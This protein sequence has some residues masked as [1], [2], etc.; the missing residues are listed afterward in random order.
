MA[1]TAKVRFAD[2]PGGGMLTLWT[3]GVDDARVTYGD[4]VGPSAP[5]GA[6]EV[7]RDD[8]TEAFVGLWHEQPW[9]FLEDYSFIRTLELPQVDL[10][11]AGL[12]G[13]HPA[14][15]LFWGYQQLTPYGQPAATP[16]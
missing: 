16:A 14:D 3:R 12:V 5:S 15:A 4:D 8:E 2:V 6:L 10:P 9:S 11:Q 7:Y 13:V 1:L